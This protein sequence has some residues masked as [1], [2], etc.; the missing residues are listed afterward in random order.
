M[1]TEVFIDH[2]KQVINDAASEHS[3]YKFY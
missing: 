1:N 2:S 3:T